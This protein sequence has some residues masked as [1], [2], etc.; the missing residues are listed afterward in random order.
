VRPQLVAAAMRWQGQRTPALLQKRS[1]EEQAEAPAEAATRSVV[2]ASTHH[3]PLR[4]RPEAMPSVGPSWKRADAVTSR[5]HTARRRPR[6]RPRHRHAG[7]QDTASGRAAAMTRLR[8]STATVSAGAST[9]RR[10]RG[11]HRHAAGA[12]A[13][14]L[15][16]RADEATGAQ[17]GPP[18]R[19]TAATGLALT[20]AA[21]PGRRA[22]PESVDGS[23]Q[24]ARQR[25]RPARALS[26]GSGPPRTQ[27]AAAVGTTSPAPAAA[28][29][30]QSAIESCRP[31]ASCQRTRSGGGGGEG[32][33]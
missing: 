30:A 4:G 32:G 12:G 18:A 7:T 14:T 19:S 22:T 3:R 20:T 21:D 31:T 10:A 24:A 33:S 5:I 29:R 11:S 16:E 15:P 17:Q 2:G 9:T 28:A 27:M 25:A 8:P 6:T 26:D 13:G 1:G 23:G